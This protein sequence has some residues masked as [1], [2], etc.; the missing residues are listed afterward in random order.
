MAKRSQSIPIPIQSSRRRSRMTRAEVVLADLEVRFARFRAAHARGTR[1]PRELREA[2]VAAVR[3]GVA[4]GAIYRTCRVSWSQLETWKVGQQSAVRRR[5][6]TRRA[7]PPDVRV[8]PV[9][10]AKP[11]DAVAV[12]STEQELELRLGRWSLRVRLAEPARG[13]YACCL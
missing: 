6:R 4:A 2:A 13:E 9:V 5:P 11:T 10:D 1:I 7:A 12:D 3:A 8:F